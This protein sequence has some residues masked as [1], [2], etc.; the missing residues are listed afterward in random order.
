MARTATGEHNARQD[1]IVTGTTYIF[2]EPAA[3]SR[4]R[5]GAG[6]LPAAQHE[7][8]GKAP[9]KSGPWRKSN[10]SVISETVF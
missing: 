4:S 10:P 1:F 2:A 8:L 6:A 7:T 5:F 3:A 9:R